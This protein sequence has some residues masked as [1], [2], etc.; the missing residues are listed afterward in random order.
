MSITNA[1]VAGIIYALTEL[2]ALS[3]TGHL[4]VVNTLFDLHLTELHLLFKAF[5]ELAVMIALILA[6][7]KDIADMIRDTAG[8][9]GFSRRPPVKGQ[10]YPE[11]RLLFMLVMATFPLLIMLPF[12]KNY[13]SLWN[14]TTFVGV[15]FILNGAVLYVCER[16][17]PGKKGLGRMQIPDA[18]II[19][20]C[21]AVAI[22]PVLHP[23]RH[24]AGHPRAVRFIYPE[25]GGRGHRR[26]RHC[27]HDSLPGRS[28]RRSGHGLFHGVWIPPSGTAPRLW[29][30]GL[31]QL[32]NRCA[33]H[34]PHTDFLILQT[35]RADGIHD[36]VAVCKDCS[37]ALRRGGE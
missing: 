5:T 11:A 33:H 21:Q 36:R 20:I 17:L 12:R 37:V 22:I 25:P 13:F 35:L 34:H 29:R 6:Y 15:M 32:G 19:G 1:V 7:R 23:L 4:A 14:S 3:G 16:M 30:A 24:A 2:L 8:L 28:G 26:D 18:L 10:R 31:L 27:V 9:T